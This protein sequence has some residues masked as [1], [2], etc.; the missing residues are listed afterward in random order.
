MTMTPEALSDAD[1]ERLAECRKAALAFVNKARAS[2]DLEPLDDLRPGVPGDARCC[3]IAASLRE[4]RASASYRYGAFTVTAYGPPDSET[5]R[6]ADL[7]PSDERVGE[8]SAAFDVGLTPDLD[9][10]ELA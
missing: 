2:F 4:L 6:M 1:R 9:S 10:R 8:F 5:S 7:S 3:T